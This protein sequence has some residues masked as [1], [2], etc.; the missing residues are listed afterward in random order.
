MSLGAG[1]QSQL[2]VIHALVLRETRTRYGAHQLGYIWALLEPLFWVL[3][4]Y[5]LFYFSN[6]HLPY[7]M[8][9][10][11]FITTGIIP[12]HLFRET[13]SRSQSAISANKGLLFYPQ[14]RPLDLVIARVSLEVV[15]LITVFAIIMG[16]HSLYLGELHIDSLLAVMGGMLLASLLGAAI[17]IFLTALGTY[18]RLVERIVPLIMRPMFFISGLFFTANELPTA[19]RELLLWNPVL[20]CVELV[21]GGWFP[22]Y[23]AVHVDLGYLLFWILGFAYSGLVLERMARRRLELT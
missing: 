15:T 18:T 11:S 17:G 20:H 2:Q 23:H 10:V 13:M 8:D 6:R 22:S 21:R 5:G 16:T 14:V 1:L 9:I 7:G 12:Y 4:F 19:A 3:T